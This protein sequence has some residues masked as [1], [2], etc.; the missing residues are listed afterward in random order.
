[1]EQDHAATQAAD[2]LRAFQDAARPALPTSLVVTAGISAGLG[3]V[4]LGQGHGAA[5]LLALV[6]AVA[7]LIA[8]FLL[9]DRWRRRRGLVG[10]RGR[11]RTEHT[12]FLLVL[13]GLAGLGFTADPTM[14]AVFV[15]LGLV[16]GVTWFWA[17][18]RRPEA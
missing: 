8:A 6:G 11:V 5:H 18:R 16:S 10:Y 4:L 3:V 7:L 1:M 15:L 9:P 17:L 2:A 13:A 12:T 14:S